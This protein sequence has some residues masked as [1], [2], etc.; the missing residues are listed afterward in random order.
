MIPDISH[1][2]SYYFLLFF[3]AGNVKILI[4]IATINYNWLWF[5]CVETLL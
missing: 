2:L 4:I 1:L 5:K 3:K